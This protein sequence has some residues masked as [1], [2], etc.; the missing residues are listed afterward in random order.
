MN[1]RTY[2]APPDSSPILIGCVGAIVMSILSCCALAGLAMAPALGDSIPPPPVAD[3]SRP[4]VTIIVKESY[5]NRVLTGSLPTTVPG[6][7]TLD[8]QPSNRLVATAVFDLALTRLQVV[9]VLRLTAEAGR[10]QVVVL[11][12]EA[13]GYD[14]MGLISL[15]GVDGNRLG[16]AMSGTIQEQV[17]AGLGEGA[18]ILGIGTDEERITITARWKSANEQ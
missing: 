1:V 17:E 10:I 2:R 5:L 14:L 13:G 6:R 8:V 15:I 9:T 4:D 11:S 3:P 7:V 12:I 18:Q 16:Q